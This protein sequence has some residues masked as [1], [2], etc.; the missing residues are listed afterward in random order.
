MNRQP[1]VSIIIAVYQA[2]DFLDECLQSIA[3]QTFPHFEVICVNDCST[4]RTAEI[5]E[6]F[7]ASDPRFRVL[8]NS[9]RRGGGASR[10]RAMR[11]A[12]GRFVY[13]MDP[14]DT[15]HP[16][17]LECVL[18]FAEKEHADVVSFRFRTNEP[19]KPD[20]S[21]SA[22]LE[23]IPYEIETEPF[24]RMGRDGDF[25]INYNYW[26]KLYLRSSLAGIDFVEGTPENPHVLSDFHHTA[27][28]LYGMRRCVMLQEKLY[29]YTRRPGS[30]TGSPIRCS[31]IANYRRAVNDM[32]DR[33][34]SD[35]SP[36][37]RR[38]L[39]DYPV[40]SVVRGQLRRLERKHRT[41]PDSCAEAEAAFREEL[42]DF[43][44]RGLLGNPGWRLRHV[45]EWWRIY[46]RLIVP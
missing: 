31:Q 29:S 1:D 45:P 30:E 16:K 10:N 36:R 37:V 17:M 32:A 35:H 24:Y 4:D 18:H 43:R 42:A 9:I 3:V 20:A 34:D 5:L 7:A 44:R 6:R 40:S 19:W 11:E 33:L 21:L 15:L 38:Q 28:A 13:F 46:R 27:C 26:T 8:H 22:P 41:D 39:R 23:K 25:R 2:E 14:D 12:S